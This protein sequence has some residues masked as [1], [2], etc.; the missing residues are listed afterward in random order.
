MD[1]RALVE[2]WKQGGFP[3]SELRRVEKRHRL[4]H[5]AKLA[6]KGDFD[7][8]DL[9]NELIQETVPATV[10]EL[11]HYRGLLEKHQ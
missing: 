9:L 7:L 4:E 8:L 5:M 11:A 1:R 3:L 2:G 10:W 6:A